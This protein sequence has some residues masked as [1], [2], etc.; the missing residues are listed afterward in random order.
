M[1]IGLSNYFYS[2]ENPRWLPQQDSFN[3]GPYVKN[4]LKWSFSKIAY[5]KHIFIISRSVGYGL[6]ENYFVLTV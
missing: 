3:I 4:I 1:F 5:I 2:D 6:M